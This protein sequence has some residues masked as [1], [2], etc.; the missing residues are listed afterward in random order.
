MVVF[1]S[2]RWHGHDQLPECQVFVGC[3]A[4]KQVTFVASS[5]CC[6]KDSSSPCFLRWP[7]NSFAG[8]LF[9]AARGARLRPPL[10]FFSTS[11][12]LVWVCFTSP[13]GVDNRSAPAYRVG[14][15][16][17]PLSASSRPLQLFLSRPVWPLR[18]PRSALCALCAAPA[19]PCACIC[20]TVCCWPLQPYS[21]PA[22]S[23]D[24]PPAHAPVRVPVTWPVWPL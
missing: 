5:V 17:E 8:S 12:T 15:M 3:L 14:T 11:C 4:F 23:L 21:V 10:E 18:G 7:A 1:P 6:G 13:F 20:G 2:W 16:P 9:V 22:R 19:H 24:R